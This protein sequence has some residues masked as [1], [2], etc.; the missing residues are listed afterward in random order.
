MEL[1]PARP[2][3]VAIAAL[4]PSVILRLS[5]SMVCRH[6]SQGLPLKL[7]L[8]DVCFEFKEKGELMVLPWVRAHVLLSGLVVAESN[9]RREQ[10]CG[11]VFHKSPW[12]LLCP[13]WM[14]QLLPCGNNWT[15]GKL[16]SYLYPSR[17][18]NQEIRELAGLQRQLEY[19]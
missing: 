11:E 3:V 18:K 8:A 9:T 19:L 14:N 5:Q 6:R 13:G 1:Q 10:E 16:C 15:D 12:I 7:N 2:F 17:T 4:P